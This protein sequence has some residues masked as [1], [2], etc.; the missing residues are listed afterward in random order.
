MLLRYS[1]GPRRNNGALVT[2]GSVMTIGLSINGCSQSKKPVRGGKTR[3]TSPKVRSSATSKG[4][5]DS[6]RA[7]FSLLLTQVSR[8]RKRALLAGW[9]WS[10]N[11]AKTTIYTNSFFV[12][13]LFLFREIIQILQDNGKLFQQLLKSSHF[14]FLLQFHPPEYSVENMATPAVL[15][16]GSNDKLASP[17]DVQ[18]L[19]KRITNLRYFQEIKGWNHADFL[20]GNDAPSVL[21]SKMLDMIEVEQFLGKNMA[22]FRLMEEE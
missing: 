13:S 15:F 2:A 7:F 17:K 4:W 6:G 20:F 3:L 10:A 16:S 22:E 19:K 14:Y 1:F 12:C 9:I 18:L 11:H 21:Y 8:I 5:H